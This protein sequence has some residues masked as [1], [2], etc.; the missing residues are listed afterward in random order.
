MVEGGTKYMEDEDGNA[1]RACTC[2]AFVP[3]PEELIEAERQAQ[4][5]VKQ[6]SKLVV[7]S[8]LLP[9]AKPAVQPQVRR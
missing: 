4:A 5:D 7:K 1:M 2:E 6:D 9:A 8:G 3:A